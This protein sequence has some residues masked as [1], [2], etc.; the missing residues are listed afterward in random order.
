MRKKLVRSLRLLNSNLQICKYVVTALV[1]FLPHFKVHSTQRHRHGHADSAALRFPGWRL[2]QAGALWRP[3][4]PR[5]TLF[6]PQGARHGR[7]GQHALQAP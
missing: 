1:P 4:L 7:C 5:L 6:H 3:R 2:H